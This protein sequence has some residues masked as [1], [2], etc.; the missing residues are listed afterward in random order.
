MDVTAMFLGQ[1][2]VGK[3]IAKLEMDATDNPIAQKDMPDLFKKCQAEVDETLKK[4]Q[5]NM[6]QEQKDADTNDQVERNYS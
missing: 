1:E 5:D 6:S 3:I 4:L 2:N